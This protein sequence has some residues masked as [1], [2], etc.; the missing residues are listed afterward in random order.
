MRVLLAGG[1]GDPIST[2]PSDL[3]LCS[4]QGKAAASPY[5]GFVAFFP[6]PV[7]IT[8]QVRCHQESRF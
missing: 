2:Y 6:T 7:A 1:A 8:K 3:S 4:G 5:K